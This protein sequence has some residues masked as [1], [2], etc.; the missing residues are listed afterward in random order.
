MKEEGGKD[1]C[2]LP[3]EHEHMVKL[4]F[5]P[6]NAEVCSRVNSCHMAL[7]VRRRFY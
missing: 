7:G 3:S 2:D 6:P 1:C 4:V 5:G